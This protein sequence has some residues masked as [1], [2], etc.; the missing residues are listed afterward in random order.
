MLLFTVLV[1]VGSFEDS[2]KFLEAARVQLADI[3]QRSA[4][5]EGRT[6]PTSA[7]NKTASTH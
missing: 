6:R 3:E 5:A 7:A 1:R 4:E 2:L